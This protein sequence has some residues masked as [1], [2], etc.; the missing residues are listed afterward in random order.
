MYRTFFVDGMLLV[1]LSVS[2]T[3]AAAAGE[4]WGEKARTRALA[5]TN[6]AGLPRKVERDYFF[7]RG[8]LGREVQVD[9]RTREISC[10]RRRCSTRSA[11]NVWQL[12]VPRNC[13]ITDNITDSVPWCACTPTKIHWTVSLEKYLNCIMASSCGCWSCADFFSRLSAS[14]VLQTNDDPGIRKLP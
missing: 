1:L 12:A 13:R 9:E 14:E 5:A 4:R 2:L 6:L 11:S 3:A 8:R 7:I 10:R